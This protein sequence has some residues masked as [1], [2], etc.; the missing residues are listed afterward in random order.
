MDEEKILIQRKDAAKILGVSG[1]MVDR[2][3]LKGLIHSRQYLPN[4]PHRYDKA[5][6]L[7]FRDG[8]LQ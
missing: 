7:A 1:Q 2:Y 6:I 8:K 5:E 4:A 3:R